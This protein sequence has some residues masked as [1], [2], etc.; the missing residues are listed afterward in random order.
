MTT[1]EL[2]KFF[3]RA[4]KIIN[5]YEDKLSVLD[6]DYFIVSNIV[7]TS[8]TDYYYCFSVFKDNQIIE[9]VAVNEASDYSKTFK[10]LSIKYKTNVIFNY[11]D[12]TTTQLKYLDDVED[13]N[14]NRDEIG[15][16]LFKR[17]FDIL[18]F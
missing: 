15:N 11:N 6:Y 4:N 9:K 8:D 16:L 13:N 14:L 18:D 2:D 7:F 3:K 12:L 1:K 17:Q 5:S 10:D